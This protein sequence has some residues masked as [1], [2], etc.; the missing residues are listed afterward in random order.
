MNREDYLNQLTDALR[1]LFAGVGATLP[2]RVRVSVGFPSTKGLGRKTR[3][4][5]EC[6]PA[7]AS[8]DKVVQIFISPLLDDVIHVGGILVH[9]LVHAVLPDAGHKKAFSSLATKL[10]LEPAKAKEMNVPGPEL[11]ARLL[12]ITTVLGPYPHSAISALLKEVK[13]QT[14]RMLKVECSKCGYTVRI[15]AKW[16]EKGTPICPTDKIPMVADGEVTEADEPEEG[17]HYEMEKAA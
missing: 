2:E 11:K 5:G 9:E 13:K 8:A 15:T 3:R 1:P 7:S 10:G 14:T 17:T 12:A 4:I 6:W 16:L